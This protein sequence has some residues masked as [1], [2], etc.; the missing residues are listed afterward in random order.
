MNIWCKWSSSTSHSRF[1]FFVP[2]L[3]QNWAEEMDSDLSPGLSAF[4][5]FIG[6]LQEQCKR[7]AKEEEETIQ[8]KNWH[9][10]STICFV[11]WRGISWWVGGVCGNAAIFKF[12]S[13]LCAY[14]SISSASMSGNVSFGFYYFTFSFTRSDQLTLLL[15]LDFCLTLTLRSTYTAPKEKQSCWRSLLPGSS[16]VHSKILTKYLVATALS[17]FSHQISEKCADCFVSWEGE[18][19]DILSLGRNV[20]RH[21]AQCLTAGHW[22]NWVCLGWA[23]C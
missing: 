4:F 2:P 16:D 1:N 6:P 23:Y 20:D 22:P 11:S 15:C 7:R 19:L 10:D 18:W 17:L 14:S 3:L 9:L 5:L 12:L 21:S 13:I 8:K